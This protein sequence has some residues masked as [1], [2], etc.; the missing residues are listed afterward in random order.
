MRSF[1]VAL[2]LAAATVTPAL[3]QTSVKIIVGGYPFTISP[4]LWR[5]TGADAFAPS[6]A[7]AVAIA[8]ALVDAGARP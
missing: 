7:E 1:I 4:D 5:Q 3:A 8:E 2:A 6:A